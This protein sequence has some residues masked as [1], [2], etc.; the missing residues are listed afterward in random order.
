MAFFS[1]FHIELTRAAHVLHRKII[2]LRSSRGN[3]R[4]ISDELKIR[5]QTVC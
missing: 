1:F 4:I 3:A 5:E 2:N